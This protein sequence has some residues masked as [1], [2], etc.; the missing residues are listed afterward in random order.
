MKMNERENYWKRKRSL[1][2]LVLGR[3][4]ELTS[5]SDS[6][7]TCWLG[8]S[9]ITFRAKVNQVRADLVPL[10]KTN[11]ESQRGEKDDMLSF[12]ELMM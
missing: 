5:F 6:N 3:K 8:S 7:S 12:F 2:H 4:H 1:F 9:N 11:R 10:P